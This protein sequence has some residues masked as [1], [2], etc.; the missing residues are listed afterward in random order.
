M[1]AGGK[2]GEIKAQEAEIVRI[3]QQRKSEI[4]P[5]RVSIV[6][7]QAEVN[8]ANAEYNRYFSLY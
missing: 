7:W 5:K 2:S 3:E 4:E 8:N 6:S 1:K